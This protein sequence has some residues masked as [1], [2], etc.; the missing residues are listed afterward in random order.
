MAMKAL[1]MALQDASYMA[2]HRQQQ[3]TSTLQ[4]L[5]SRV[6]EYAQDADKPRQAQRGPTIGQESDHSGALPEEKTWIVR[7]PPTAGLH[8]ALQHAHSQIG[9]VRSED[10]WIASDQNE[11]QP[12]A[13]RATANIPGFQ[14]RKPFLKVDRD[15]HDLKQRLDALNLRYDVEDGP[16]ALHFQFP[17]EDVHPGIYTIRQWGHRDQGGIF[18]R[19][20]FRKR[21][22]Q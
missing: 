12:G 3:P 8:L 16:T 11:I 10:A 7:L 1:T 15:S 9:G 14:R 6:T 20:I 18:R 2:S 19:R 21:N 13:A 5:M 4:N 22:K 17:E